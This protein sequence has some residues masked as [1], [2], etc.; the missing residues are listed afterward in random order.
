MKEPFSPL[1]DLALIGDRR[2]CALLDKQGNMV[3]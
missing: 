3:W 1:H 2:T